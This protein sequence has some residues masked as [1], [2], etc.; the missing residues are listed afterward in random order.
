M[1]SPFPFPFV[2]SESVKG[3]S[4]TAL[5]RPVWTMVRRSRRIAQ[6]TTTTE[7]Q[8]VSTSQ[9]DQPNLVECGACF[10]W[11]KSCG[12]AQGDTQEEGLQ[13]KEKIMATIPA[14]LS[15]NQVLGKLGGVGY[16]F[17]CKK[18][19]CSGWASWSLPF[20]SPVT[21]IWPALSTIAAAC[22]L[23]W[24]QGYQKQRMDCHSL[25]SLALY[26]E[27]KLDKHRASW[28]IRS[29]PSFP[30]QKW[31]SMTANWFWVP[32]RERWIVSHW[33]DIPCKLTDDKTLL[34]ST[35]Q[36]GTALLYLMQQIRWPAEVHKVRKKQH[37]WAQCRRARRVRKS[38]LNVCSER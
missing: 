28:K 7:Q 21:K 38:W 34:S 9:P 22:T 5:F 6:R 24:R 2:F 33:H 23:T 19:M 26:A 35:V 16:V 1:W 3:E 12:D 30:M 8:S 17:E 32:L 27:W 20:R 10:D 4:L 37:R 31:R 25:H 14:E 13:E 15:S 18:G 36:I 29:R 11:F